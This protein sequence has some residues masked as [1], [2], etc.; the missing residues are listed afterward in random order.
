M[1]IVSYQWNTIKILRL[2]LH[3]KD[4]KRNSKYVY[5]NILKHSILKN[6]K[7]FSCTILIKIYDCII[8]LQLINKPVNIV[9]LND[10]LF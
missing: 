7:S 6:K 4:V 5:D 2:Y 10:F 3:T 1:K 8:F 9:Q